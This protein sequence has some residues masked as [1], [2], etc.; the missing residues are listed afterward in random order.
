MAQ[1][2]KKNKQF[3]GTDGDDEIL[4]KRSVS[5]RGVSRCAQI[6]HRGWYVRPSETIAWSF[7]P[8]GTT[9]RVLRNDR[10]RGS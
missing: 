5:H 4:E 10:K 3:Q 9:D 1:R 8:A 6:Y 2:N 7:G